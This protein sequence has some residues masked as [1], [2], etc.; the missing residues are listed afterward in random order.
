MRCVER[1]GLEITDIILQPL[2]AGEYALSKDEKNLGVALIDLGGG[3]TTIAYF[4]EG[5]LAATSVIPVGGDLITNDLS[6][7]LHTSTEDAEKIKVKYGHAF[8]MMPQ[9]MSSLVFQLSE[10]ISISNLINYMCLKL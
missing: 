1:A 4:E 10:A 2:A 7:V 9:K 5:F 6:K 3:S 8:T